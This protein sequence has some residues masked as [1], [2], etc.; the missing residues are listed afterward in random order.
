MSWFVSLPTWYL[1]KHG[2]FHFGAKLASYN[3]PWDW[4]RE[5]PRQI[6]HIIIIDIWFF[7]THRLIHV[8]K[9]INLYKM[10]HKFHHKFTAPCAPACMYANPIEFCIGNVLG[11]IL[12]PCLTNCHP[13]TTLFWLT[14]SL[15]ST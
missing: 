11:I 12:G 8:K 7:T 2:T 10:I 15:V 13:L 1:H 3:D 6:L 9:P 4:Q 5:V 14:T